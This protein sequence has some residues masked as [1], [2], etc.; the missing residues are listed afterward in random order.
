MSL[1]KLDE[2]KVYGKALKLFD[3]VFEDM[4]LLHDFPDTMRLRSQQI[5]SIDSICSNIEEGAGRWSTKEY[6]QYLIFARGSAAESRG[7]YLRLRHWL[8]ERIVEERVALCNEIIGGLTKSIN[9][10]KGRGK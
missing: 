3:L 5:A 8:P 6:V 9:S 10:L 4:R 7:R 1:E 2:Y